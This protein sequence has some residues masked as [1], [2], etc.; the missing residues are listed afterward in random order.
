MELLEAMAATLGQPASTHPP[1]VRYVTCSHTHHE[2]RLLDATSRRCRKNEREIV[3]TKGREG[4]WSRFDRTTKTEHLAP[5][6]HAGE[7]VRPLG[8]AFYGRV[9]RPHGG[10]RDPTAREDE[11]IR[12]HAPSEGRG[13]GTGWRGGSRTEDD[14]RRIGCRSVLFDIKRRAL[15]LIMTIINKYDSDMD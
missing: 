14:D 4:L 12:T 8:W 9:T 1:E 15:V 13:R 2:W 5:F 7:L 11:R 3:T 10:I 6:L